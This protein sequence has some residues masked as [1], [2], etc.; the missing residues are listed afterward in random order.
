M[1]SQFLLMDIITS[2]FLAVCIFWSSQTARY[3]AEVHVFLAYG[4]AQRNLKFLAR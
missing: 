3:T 4:D 2:K 1:M